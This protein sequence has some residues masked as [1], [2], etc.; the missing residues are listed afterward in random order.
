MYVAQWMFFRCVAIDGS[1]KDISIR[2]FDEICEIAP[3]SPLERVNEKLKRLLK[4]L[5]Y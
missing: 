3:S 5:W 2:L 1:I 4:S